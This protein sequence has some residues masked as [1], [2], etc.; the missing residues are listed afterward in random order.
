MIGKSLSQRHTL[1]AL[2]SDRAIA[3]LTSMLAAQAKNLVAVRAQDAGMVACLVVRADKLSVRV[4]R[5]LGFQLKLGATAV[6]GLQGADAAALFP[7]L[8]PAQRTWLET[9][10]GARETKV[11]LIA[12]GTALLSLETV[13]GKVTITAVP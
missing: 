13:D 12:G 1:G 6:F 5:E 4:C 8:P 11:L 7:A 10:C 3:V 2:A 9:P